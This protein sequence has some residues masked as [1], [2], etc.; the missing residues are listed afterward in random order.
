MSPIGRSSGGCPRQWGTSC[1]Q[2]TKRWSL[3]AASA[4]RYQWAWVHSR[5]T[6]SSCR[7]SS[8]SIRGPHSPPIRLDKK[9]ENHKIRTDEPKFVSFN[10]LN[11]SVILQ[12]IIPHQEMVKVTYL[13]RCPCCQRNSVR[14]VH[15]SRCHPSLRS[16][17]IPTVPHPWHDTDRG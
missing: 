10:Q 2:R 13:C 15:R 16:S 5:T 3:V 17:G 1:A 12:G 7:P 11:S 8:G 6:G 4:T 14:A 9:L